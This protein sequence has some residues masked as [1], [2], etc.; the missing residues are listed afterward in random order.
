MH[1]Y[2]TQWVSIFQLLVGFILAP[3]QNLPGFGTSAYGDAPDIWTQLRRGKDCWLEISKECEARSTFWLLPGYVGINFVFNTLGLYL[4]KRS[5]AVL[6]SIAYALLLPVT[7]LTFSLN[8]L[9][10]YQEKITEFTWIGLSLTI[11]GFLLYRWATPQSRASRKKKLRRSTSL[12][13]QGQDSEVNTHRQHRTSSGSNA[14]ESNRVGK[15]EEIAKPTTT[16]AVSTEIV[17]GRRRLPTP[18]IS[19]NHAAA[20]S[21]AATVAAHAG[22]AV[23]GKDSPT[24]LCGGVK[25]LGGVFTMERRRSPAIE[26]DDD[27]DGSIAEGGGRLPGTPKIGFQERT[28]AF[29]IVQFTEDAEDAGYDSEISSNF[30]CKRDGDERSAI[31]T[32]QANNESKAPNQVQYGSFK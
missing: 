10:P 21:T 13:S 27:A 2:L 32:R 12:R 17:A 11:F 7:T 25:G 15:G 16:T 20:F 28:G 19:G 5:S 22:R 31:I 18:E 3:L 29:S 9:G 24:I 4:T 26:G 23:E 14:E 30:E 6:T 8:I 1:S